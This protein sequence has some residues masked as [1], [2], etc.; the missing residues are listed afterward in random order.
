MKN[1][2]YVVHDYY[3]YDQFGDSDYER[4]NIDSIWDREEDAKRRIDDLANEYIRRRWYDDGY[5]DPE[6]FNIIQVWNEDKTDV[7]CYMDDYESESYYIE[8][9]EINS[10]KEFTGP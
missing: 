7:E 6:D 3:W 8:K 1:F 5:L 10:V 9:I 4:D 2:V